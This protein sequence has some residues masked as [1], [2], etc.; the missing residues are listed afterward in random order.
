M[1]TTHHMTDADWAAVREKHANMTSEEAG[2]WI[3]KVMGPPRR[4]LEGEEREQVLTM[5]A[6]IG[7]TVTTNNQ[8]SWSEDYIQGGKHWC[9]TYFPGD[10]VMVEE[11][12]I[13]TD[14]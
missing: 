7:P 9:V 6:L 11:M 3:R 5:L 4:T 2:A 10:E 8:H 1:T 12:E 13:E 14:Q